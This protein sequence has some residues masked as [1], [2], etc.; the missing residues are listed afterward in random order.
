MKRSAYTAPGD[1]LAYR[2]PRTVSLS[3]TRR[4]WHSENTMHYIADSKRLMELAEGLEPP[5]L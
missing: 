5:T 2:P 4:D 3:T 1:E